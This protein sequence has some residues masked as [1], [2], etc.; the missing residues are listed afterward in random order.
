MSELYFPSDFLHAKQAKLIPLVDG[1]KFTEDEK[2]FFRNNINLF[3]HIRSEIVDSISDDESGTLTSIT[4]K[5]VHHHHLASLDFTYFLQKEELMSEKNNART[6]SEKDAIQKEIDALNTL[7]YEDAVPY[8]DSV[9][10]ILQKLGYETEDNI[11]PT[12]SGCFS[13]ITIS[14]KGA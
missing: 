11:N 8:V 2:L 12:K 13:D 9:I 7:T 1:L 3:Y 5:D 4:F 14:W 10:G 6:D